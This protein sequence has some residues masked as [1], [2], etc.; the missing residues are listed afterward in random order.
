M[1]GKTVSFNVASDEM[2]QNGTKIRQWAQQNEN[3]L[4]KA[5]ANEVIDVFEGGAP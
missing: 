2:R 4:L 5:L 1:N 3:L